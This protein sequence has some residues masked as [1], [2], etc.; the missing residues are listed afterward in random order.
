MIPRK[1]IFERKNDMGILELFKKKKKEVS[2]TIPATI[3]T[4]ESQSDSSISLS[5]SKDSI[6]EELDE[7]NVPDEAVAAVSSD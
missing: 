3:P 7:R 2:P 1:G 5:M 6:L 4:E